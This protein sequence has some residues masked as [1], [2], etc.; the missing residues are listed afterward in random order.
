MSLSTSEKVD[1]LEEQSVDANNSDQPH[2]FEGLPYNLPDKPVV[3]IETRTSWVPLN[4]RDLWA[5]RELLYFLMW[6]DVKVRYKQTVLGVAWA[7]IQPLITMLIFAYFF[8]KLARVPTDGV[9]YPIFVYAAVLLWTFFSNSVT[10]GA[11]SLTGN[12]NLITKVYF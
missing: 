9:P 10:N 5:Y 3:T 4:L 8:G 2:D 7:V 6:R 12:S 11:S 1:S